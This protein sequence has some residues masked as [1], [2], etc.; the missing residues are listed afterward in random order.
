MKLSTTEQSERFLIRVMRKHDLTNKKTK[1]RPVLFR[2]HGQRTT[3]ES[4]EEKK[5]DPPKDSDKYNDKDRHL[6]S[7]PKEQIVIPR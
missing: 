3:L 7:T 2:K 4:D 5:A 1:T 6:E